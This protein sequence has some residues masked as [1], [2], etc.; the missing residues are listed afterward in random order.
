MAAADWSIKQPYTGE[1][2]IHGGGKTKGKTIHGGDA[3]SVI[4]IMGGDSDHGALVTGHLLAFAIG[5]LVGYKPCAI[6]AA[7][8]WVSSEPLHSQPFPERI[9]RE[10][11]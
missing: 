5:K 8:W 7:S 10:G 1:N 11:R 2:H 6:L 3:P 4:A 9:I